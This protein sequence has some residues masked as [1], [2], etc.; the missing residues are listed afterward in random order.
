MSQF[1]FGKTELYAHRSQS[2]PVP[3]GFDTT[4][5]LTQDPHAI[6]ES[7]RPLP[8][9]YWKGSGLS[10]LLDL[11]ASMLSGGL[12]T[13]QIGQKDP[14]FGVSQ[15]YIAFDASRAMAPDV[16]ERMVSETLDFVK[17][18][19]PINAGDEV[20]FPGERVLK[21]RRENLEKGI[22]VDRAIWE[23]ILTL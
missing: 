12:S 15:V 19:T 14:E 11:M 21:T 8:I 22:P 2:L 1:S 3:G 10:L 18:A 5:N 13:R 6:L 17:S 16:I 20:V 23:Q 4:G 9:G 7:G